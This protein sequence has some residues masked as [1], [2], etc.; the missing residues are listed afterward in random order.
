M[1]SI[2][3]SAFHFGRSQLHDQERTVWIDRC[4]SPTNAEDPDAFLTL[5]SPL[6]RK[7]PK[8]KKTNLRKF[9]ALLLHPNQP[10]IILPNLTPSV[11]F[12]HPTADKIFLDFFGIFSLGEASSPFLG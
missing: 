9:F 4:S 1:N 10:L 8:E 6:K 12:W 2:C 3:C 7:A 5:A 11:N